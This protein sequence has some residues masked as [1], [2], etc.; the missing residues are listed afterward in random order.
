MEDPP[1]IVKCISEFFRDLYNKP[2]VHE[3]DWNE[4]WSVKSLKDDEIRFLCRKA[5][6]MKIE[7]VAKS[8][9]LDKSP[10][11]DGF[12]AA[13]TKKIGILLR[14]T[15]LELSLASFPLGNY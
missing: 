11:L 13:F 9:N 7:E 1:T 8:L 15:L 3:V 14:R 6:S 5:T 4:N 2:T 10:G 12:N